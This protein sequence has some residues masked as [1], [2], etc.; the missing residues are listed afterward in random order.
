MILKTA[1]MM[2]VALTNPMRT[3]EATLLM[4]AA[5]VASPGSMDGIGLGVGVVGG[6]AETKWTGV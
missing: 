4:A 1:K 5:A 2:S 3:N 6:G